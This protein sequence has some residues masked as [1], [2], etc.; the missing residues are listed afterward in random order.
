MVLIELRDWSDKYAYVTHMIIMTQF[1]LKTSH[2]SPDPVHA[3][4]STLS[5]NSGTQMVDNECSI[6]NNNSLVYINLVLLTRYV[7]HIIGIRL[8]KIYMSNYIVFIMAD[9]LSVNLYNL[10]LMI[11]ESPTFI[12]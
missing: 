5:C 12:L 1:L 6:N 8:K 10:T 4:F 7:L 3:D 9:C 11:D 2:V